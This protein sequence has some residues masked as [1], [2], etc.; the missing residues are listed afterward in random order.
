M[1]EGG[2][3]PHV[4]SFK[5]TDMD[6]QQVISN[7]FFAD[8]LNPDFYQGHLGISSGNYKLEWEIQDTASVFEQLPQ[9]QL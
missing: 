6:S 7:D 8:S 1:R 5:L 2:C 4:D 9:I 3:Y